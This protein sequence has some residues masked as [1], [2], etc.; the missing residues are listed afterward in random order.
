MSDFIEVTHRMNRKILI[1]K[2][3]VISLKT[4]Q[5]PTGTFAILEFVVGARGE[6]VVL[7]DSY[8][9]IK[10]LLLGA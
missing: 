1:R 10:K 5:R 7:K 6:T 2:S 9:E 8:D 3:C 4:E